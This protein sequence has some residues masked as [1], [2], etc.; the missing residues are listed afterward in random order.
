MRPVASSLYWIRRNQP[1]RLLS[2]NCG[3]ENPHQHNPI[4]PQT[5]QTIAFS[6]LA[7]GGVQS[8][9]YT[10]NFG[11]GSNGRGQTISHSYSKYGTYT[12]TVTVTDGVGKMLTASRTLTV[13][14]APL[15]G[16]ICLQCFFKSNPTA[17]L[18]LIGLPVGL[19][20][21]IGIMTFVKKRRHK[22]FPRLEDL[23]PRDHRR[24]KVALGMLLVRYQCA[25]MAGRILEPFFMWFI[26]VGISVVA[27]TAGSNRPS[28]PPAPTH[29]AIHE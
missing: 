2:L 1:R 3:S 12:T 20:L 14:P 25:E 11:D 26:P 9:S 24:E 18:L 13:A 27:A 29:L 8:Y 16:G 4:H 7:S 17:S 22:T 21:A 5:S 28:S 23:P 6:G 19:T 15:W 10:W